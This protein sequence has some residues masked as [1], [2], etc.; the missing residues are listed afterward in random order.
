MATELDTLLVKIK[1]DISGLKKG[2]DKANS[3]VSKS[4]RKMSSSMKEFRK[5]LDRVGKRVLQFGSLF[6]VAFGGYQLKKVVD[7]GRVV[8]DLQVRLKA[9]FGSAE[10]GAKSFQVM[11]EYAGKVPFSLG[12]IQKG[13]GNLAVVAKDAAELKEILFL[14]GNVAA[15]TG[16]DFRQTAEQIQ[17]SFSSG[18]ASADVFRER[19]VG[20][21]LGFQKGAEVS[22]AET[23]KVFKEAFGKGG[24]FGNVTKDLAATLTGTL[25]MLGD[26]LLQFR[27][28]ISES[29]T[30]EIKK[31]LAG[32]NKAL[33]KSS[34]EIEK[35][36]KEIGEKL[37]GAVALFAENID[38]IIR[39][40]TALAIFLT[41]AMGA[42]I[43][44]FVAGLGAIGILVGALTVAWVLWGDKILVVNYFILLQKKLLAGLSGSFENSKGKVITL[45]EA[46]EKI[47][48]LPAH[49]WWGGLSEAL[50]LNK[51]KLE[52]VNEAMKIVIA[53][54]EQ[55]KEITTDLTKVFDDMGKDVSK[56]FGSAVV[57]GTSFRDAM[58]SILVSV[59]EQIVA[60]IA[61][62]LII[63]PL[64][65]KLTNSLKAYKNEISVSVGGGGGILDTLVKVGISAFAGGDGFG[66]GTPQIAGGSPTG[67]AVAGMGFQR[68]IAYIQQQPMSYG[69]LDNPADYTPRASGGFVSPSMPY[70]VGEKGAEMFMPKS[71]GTI[72]PNNKMGAGGVTINQSLNFSTGVVPT[73]RAEVRNLMPQIKKET[74]SAVAE[75]KSRGGA[76]ART[77]GS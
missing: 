54:K 11:L 64:I 29:F 34:K 60:T 48:K 53:T 3:Q 47:H 72:I 28:A 24:K 6:A 40:L 55:L 21:L 52:E 41:G 43:V 2:L 10:E 8:E 16:L 1:A 70:M 18:I 76:F 71:A 67:S 19:G 77:F 56:A 12:E 26:K 59:S 75:A 4:S 45:T 14:T 58:R 20:S 65:K 63:E 35:I 15:T 13:S 7:A 5:S 25:S 30:A 74:V 17:R 27:L 32:M 39:G 23:I 33:Q 9:L 38:V 61:Q 31:Q 62:I 44:G 46:L 51:T 73:V 37:A 69:G 49:K 42:V 57:S 36:G 66:A 68:N 50:G 22:V